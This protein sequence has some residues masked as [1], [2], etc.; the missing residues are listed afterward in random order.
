MYHFT[1][2]DQ[3]YVSHVVDLWNREWVDRFPMRQVLFLQNSIEDRNVLTDGS[4]VVLDTRTD[5]AIGLIIS[6]K[7]SA[8]D[9]YGAM[10]IDDRDTGWI[11]VLLI[12]R[13]YRHQG[14]GSKLLAHAEH[15]L[16]L[17]GAKKIVLGGDPWHYFPAVPADDVTVFNWF[18]KRGYQAGKTYYDLLCHEHRMPII[19]A[20]TW[21]SFASPS[22]KDRSAYHEPS[23][24][25]P[26]Y[27][28]LQFDEKDRFLA[29]MH[30]TFPG[31]WAYEAYHYFLKGGKGR[32][33]LIV[34]KEGRIVG[35]CRLHD[36]QSPFIAQNVYWAPLF[37]N[38]RVG[39]VGPL[40]LEP[41]TRGAGYG[42]AMVR[43]A[44]E[45]LFLRGL[46]YVVIDWTEL[47]EFYGRLGCRT[48]KRYVY[49]EKII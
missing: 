45:E 16:V 20:H 40:G 10:L 29:F 28:L 41:N 5:E 37:P 44:L 48:W 42:L 25:H 39:G 7:L 46:E 9:P 6:K 1:T 33:I 31:R 24:A 26:T 4:L 2:L 22:L 21:M 43:A 15:A 19:H 13:R 38:I 3:R 14:L 49:Y 36:D 47:L 23:A 12:D 34:E 27:R 32:E 11:Q 8:T 17:N 30:Q 18:Q 35:F